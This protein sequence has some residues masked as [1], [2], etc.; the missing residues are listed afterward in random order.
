MLSTGHGSHLVSLLHPWLTPHL[1]AHQ[2]PMASYPVEPLYDAYGK[3]LVMRPEYTHHGYPMAPQYP[4]MAQPYPMMHPGPYP[5]YPVA[6][7]G[8]NQGGKMADACL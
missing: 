8:Y 3:P 1:S 4:G 7:P 6:D 2:I 5:S